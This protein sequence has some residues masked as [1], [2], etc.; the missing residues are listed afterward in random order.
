MTQWDGRGCCAVVIRCA[1]AMK[2]V[3]RSC[4]AMLLCDVVDWQMMCCELQRAQDSKNLET[5][6]PVRGGTLQCN[7]QKDFY[8][9]VIKNAP[10]Y[11]HVLQCTTVIL[12]IYYKVLLRTTK[13][14]SKLQSTNP[15]TTM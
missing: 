6:F 12:Q 8:E 10:P 14:Y 13:C 1:C 7:T 11:Y 15:F 3:V 5:S 2:L 4:D 9:S